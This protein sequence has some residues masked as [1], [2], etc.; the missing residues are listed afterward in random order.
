[1]D[2]SRDPLPLSSLTERERDILRLLSSGLS[3]SEIAEAAVLTVGT[4]KWYNRQIYSKLGVRN[5]TQAMATAQ[6][7]GLLDRAPARATAQRTPPHNLPAQLTSFIGRERE[8][9]DLRDVVSRS[10]L[11]TLTGPPGTGK[12]R[13]ALELAS[14]LLGGYRDG[15]FAVWLAPLQD[16]GLV[17][18]AVAQALGIKAQGSESIA[19]ALTRNLR[20]KHLLLLLDNFEHVIRAAPLVSELLAAAPR[21]TVLV[22]SREN[23]HLYGETE[24]PV[25]PLRV[26]DLRQ[27]QTGDARQS[28]AVELFMQRARAA[29]PGFALDDDN[30]AAVATI[31]VHLD[32]LPLAIELAAARIKY[33]A[34]Q[35]LLMRLGSR[36]EALD[37]GPRDLPARQRTLRTTLAWSYDLLDAEEQLLFS[38]LGVFAGGCRADDA[39]AVCGDGRPLDIA[40]GLESLLNKSLLR[41]ERG[42]D[43][44][45]RFLMLETM[46]E[47]ALEK[48]DASGETAMMRERHALHFLALTEAGRS[49]FW[50]PGDGA[51]LARLDSDHDNLRA[52]LQ[53][54]LTMDDPRQLSLRLIAAIARLWEVRGHFSEGY[55]WLTEALKLTHNAAPTRERAAA[56]QSVAR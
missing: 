50:G 6:T 7:L 35:T 17:V 15:V 1:M 49:K 10:R 54:S 48:L 14:A 22:T 44:E 47:F 45:P 33:Y 19:D 56:L 8:V 3:D 31:C 52:A 2:D 13:L 12:T 32:G 25:P 29:S 18:H 24:Y 20:D 5:R 39:A 30:A 16:S 28:E 21:L 38:R 37:S 41:H 9:A 4:V 36:L 51:W 23:L 53:W 42:V 46:R 55:S 27:P 34:P 26:P 43:G 40:A 11:V